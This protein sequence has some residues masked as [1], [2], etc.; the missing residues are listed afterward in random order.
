MG[1]VDTDGEL[2]EDG[3]PELFEYIDTEEI[4]SLVDCPTSIHDYSQ[5]TIV[6]PVARS[7]SA[8]VHRRRCRRHGTPSGDTKLPRLLF[9]QAAKLLLRT[10]RT[11]DTFRLLPRLVPCAKFIKSQRTRTQV[12]AFV[13]PA[14]IAYD[15]A[16]V[17][18]RAAP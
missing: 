11:G 8:R 17:E 3:G 2:Y 16:R 12:G 6:I 4:C 15:F 5:R 10:R 7:A 13:K 18:G 14:L 1:K 9:H